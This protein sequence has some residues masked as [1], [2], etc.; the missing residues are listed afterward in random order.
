MRWRA[1]TAWIAGGALV[2]LALVGEAGADGVGAERG[3]IANLAYEIRPDVD[4]GVEA[5][6]TASGEAAAAVPD[7]VE[8]TDPQTVPDPSDSSVAAGDPALEPT[9]VAATDDSAGAA[10]DP[11]DET[12]PVGQSTPALEAADVA[13]TGEGKVCVTLVPPAVPEV[14]DPSV[15]EPSEPASAMVHLGIP[16]PE[17]MT[18]VDFGTFADAQSSEVCV[19]MSATGEGL[20]PESVEVCLPPS[21][22][23]SPVGG[24]LPGG[25]ELPRAAILQCLTEEAPGLASTDLLSILP[26]LGAGGSQGPSAADLE[27]VRARAAPLR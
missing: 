27:A 12:A 22:G 4:G 15:P 26:A 3:T 19:A 16:T 5:C 13:G 7:G 6:F 17:G 18:E 10:G 14:P 8:P 23:D 9:P 21:P 25:L 2:G 11:A 1:R 20:E 24:M